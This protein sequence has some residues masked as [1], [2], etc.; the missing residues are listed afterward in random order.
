MTKRP[1]TLNAY[2]VPLVIA[3][4]SMVG[5]VAALVA[6]GPGD[7]TSWIALFAPIAVVVWA[8]IFRRR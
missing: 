5:L 3:L 8:F 1:S 7:W 6:D 2:T 4:I